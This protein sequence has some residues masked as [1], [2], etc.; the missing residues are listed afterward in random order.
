MKKFKTHQ[1]HFDAQDDTLLPLLQAPH[2]LGAVFQHYLPWSRLLLFGGLSVGLGYAQ[3]LSLT[4]LILCGY[5]T[6]A[7][8]SLFYMMQAYQKF[9]QHQ[10]ALQ[11]I[12][13]AFVGQKRY[14]L[15]M[16]GFALLL[17][18]SLGWPAVIFSTLILSL[19]LHS[20]RT[21]NRWSASLAL[22]GSTCVSLSQLPGQA[23]QDPQQLLGVGVFIGLWAVIAF[24]P[25][26]FKILRS[27]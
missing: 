20:G 11:N 7:L 27:A 16:G 24:N 8:S 2:L 26:F 1:S 12:H 14:L 10:Q 6:L 3:N 18:A 23:F 19:C 5:L 21:Q 17:A 13:Y 22:A 4:P 15:L 25:G 9:R